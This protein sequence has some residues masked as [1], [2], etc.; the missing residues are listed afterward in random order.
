MA[1]ASWPWDCRAVLRSVLKAFSVFSVCDLCVVDVYTAGL[2]HVTRQYSRPVP[3]TGTGVQL[4]EYQYLLLKPVSF[5]L[6][7]SDPMP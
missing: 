7:V 3:S 1:H 2:S 5:K 4:Y 6:G